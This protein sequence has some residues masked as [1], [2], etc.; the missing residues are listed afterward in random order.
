LRLKGLHVGFLA[1]VFLPLLASVSFMPSKASRFHFTAM[2]AW[3]SYFWVFPG[4][5][6]H[7]AIASNRSLCR[8]TTH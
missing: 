3:I 2:L 7:R 4:Q 6:S 5:F 8:S 1:E